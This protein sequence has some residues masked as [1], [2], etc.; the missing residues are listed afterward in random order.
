LVG[1][2]GSARLAAT[3]PRATGTAGLA[4]RVASESRSAGSPSTGPAGMAGRTAESRSTWIGSTG[5]A[6][7]AGR[8][9]AAHPRPSR[10]MAGRTTTSRPRSARCAGSA[11]RPIPAAILPATAVSIAP[12]P[13]A[14]ISA[15]AV[16]AT[17]V[18][19]DAGRP[20]LATRLRSAAMANRT[21]A[22]TGPTRAACMATHRGAGSGATRGPV[23]I[24]RR[25]TA[26]LAPCRCLGVL[27]LAG[28]DARAASAEALR[29]DR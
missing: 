16:P 13:T 11:R 5:P 15:A 26:V 14:A 22:G 1:L 28:T 2:P 19:P 10:G 27:R 24:S 17:A 21:R 20:E 4:G 18:P 7:M 6:G 25:S 3:R 29:R 9:T 23:A 12:I 8:D